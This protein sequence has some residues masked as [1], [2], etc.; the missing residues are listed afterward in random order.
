VATTAVLCRSRKAVPL[1]EDHTTSDKA[2]QARVVSEG[3]FM[4]HDGEGFR[5][6]GELAVTR[7]FG[8]VMPGRGLPR[9]PAPQAW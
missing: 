1:S 8:D 5:V 4:E 6:G 3:G 2:E 7:A 9:T